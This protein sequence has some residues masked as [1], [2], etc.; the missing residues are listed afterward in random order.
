MDIC[1]ILYSV[2][3]SARRSCRRAWGEGTLNSRKPQKF[4]EPGIRMC[5]VIMV[6]FALATFFFNRYLAYGEAAVTVL[7]AI[8]ALIRARARQKELQTFVESVTYNAESATN[9]TLRCV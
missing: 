1:G 9:N 4:A 7:L 8:Y 5:L 2:F 3:L 6:I